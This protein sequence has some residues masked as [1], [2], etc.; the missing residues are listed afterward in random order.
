MI[1]ITSTEINQFNLP[2]DSTI[3]GLI[4]FI[5]L[6]IVA[7]VMMRL[8]DIKNLKVVLIFFS[9]LCVFMYAYGVIT[10]FFVVISFL[11][12]SI[13]FYN[14]ISKNKGVDIE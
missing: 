5:F 4:L 3:N 2:F 13:I 7:F 11:I 12:D 8:L 6:L 14:E 10:I 9:I 1:Q